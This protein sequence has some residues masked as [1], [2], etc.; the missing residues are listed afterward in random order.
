[1]EL[2]ICCRQDKCVCKCMETIW[3]RDLWLPHPAPSSPGP[4]FT[5]SSCWGPGSN[6]CPPRA[7]IHIVSSTCLQPDPF[8]VRASSTQSLSGLVTTATPL[9]GVNVST[10]LHIY[11]HM[12]V[13]YVDTCSHIQLYTHTCMCAYTQTCTQTHT[14]LVYTHTHSCKY[15]HI[16]E[17]TQVHLT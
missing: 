6:P 3:K 2:A 13:P 16:C 8:W 17:H 15:I 5:Q 9:L 4:E 1:M 12:N 10:H 7:K 11:S 14:C